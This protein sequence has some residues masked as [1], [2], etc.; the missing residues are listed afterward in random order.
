[1][2]QI[3]TDFN[4]IEPDSEVSITRT[5]DTSITGDS[6]SVYFPDNPIV[7][8]GDK[9]TIF[10]EMVVLNRYYPFVYKGKKYLLFR[11][12]KNTTEI[13]KVTG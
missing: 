8:Q 4:V 1:M 11:P 12:K 13:Y 2:Q 9:V 5:S 10:G 7:T 3:L 6:A